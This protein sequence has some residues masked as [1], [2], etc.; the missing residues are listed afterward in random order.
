MVPVSRREESEAGSLGNRISFVFIDLPVHRHRPLD[1]LATIHAATQAF[2]TG[3]RAAGGETVLGALGALPE[4][5]KTPAARMA[6]SPR[7]YNLTISNVPGP[8]MPVYL[9]GAELDARLP[10]DP[11]L[12]GPRALGRAS[13]ATT[14]RCASAATR[15]RRR[16]RRRASCPRR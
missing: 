4:P 7:M 9:L 2:K 16:C 14:R 15:T 8:R 12:R 11:D 3:G 10:G 5:L 13:S 1:R 6:A